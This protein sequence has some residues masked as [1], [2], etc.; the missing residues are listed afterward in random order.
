MVNGKPRAE[1]P[2]LPYISY[3]LNVYNLLSLGST[4]CTTMMNWA[5]QEAVIINFWVTLVDEGMTTSGWVQP[6]VSTLS[7]PYTTG[8]PF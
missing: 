8:R 1:A 4:S 7:R 5:F 3:V 6:V 2:K